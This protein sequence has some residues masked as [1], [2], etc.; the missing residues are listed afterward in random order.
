ME[1]E[2]TIRSPIC[3]VMGHVDA[4]KTTLLDAIR[5]TK[6]A[7]AEA[8]GITQT[9]AATTLELNSIIRATRKIKGKFESSA[10]RGILP[11]ILM[12]DTP[13]HEAFGNL[14]GLGANL[15]DI[16]IVAIDI[17]EGLQPQTE[18]SIR[19]LISHKIPFI[20][21]LTKLDKVYNWRSNEDCDLKTSFKKQSKDS[22]NSLMGYIDG[23]KHDLKTKF[24]IKSEFYVKNKK[25]ESVYSIVAVN[26]LLSEGI[27]DLLALI[28]YLST[29]WMTKRLNFS[30]DRLEATIMEVQFDKKVGWVIDVILANGRLS[31]GD[32]VF[33]AQQSGLKEITIRSMQDR[34]ASL[35]TVTASRSIR[36]LATGLEGTVAGTHIH[37]DHD[38]ATSELSSLELGKVH[39][40]SGVILAAPTLGALQ[41]CQELIRLTKVREA[42]TSDLAKLEIR[43]TH[44]GPIQKRDLDRWAVLSRTTEQD[45]MVLYFGDLSDAAELTEYAKVLDLCLLVNPVVYKLLESFTEHFERAK[46]DLTAKYLKEGIVIYPFELQIL[47]QYMFMRGGGKKQHILCGVKVVGG[48]LNKDMPICYVK[49]GEVHD[50]GKVLSVQKEKKEVNE[51]IKEGEEVCIRIENP[52]NYIYERHFNADTSFFSKVTRDSI[53]VLKDG[54]RDKMKKMDWLL[55][56]RIKE[57]MGI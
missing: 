37:R 22:Q 43:Q 17:D 50:L 4:G 25:P 7:D 8:G 30:E 38:S 55:L 3:A 9:I 39:A 33:V 2:K 23:V 48:R 12:I 53:D 13:G 51:E 46:K 54:F 47:K 32:K 14:R 11:G 57:E 1:S 15:C 16:S 27:A 6:Y 24:K 18:E 44:I 35:S 56:I 40:D 21:V 49:D 34:G 45:N 20:V 41:A 5:K 10:A 31:V 19:L 42:E 26:S 29:N 36:I 28:V 52:N